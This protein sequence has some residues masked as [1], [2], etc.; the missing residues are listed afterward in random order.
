[1]YIGPDL[2]TAGDYAEVVDAGVVA[3]VDLVGVV[4]GG[5][6]AD[7][8]VLAELMETHLRELRFCQIGHVS[9]RG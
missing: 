3:D 8:N 2:D 6:I 9:P 1:M 5:L 4:D 7:P